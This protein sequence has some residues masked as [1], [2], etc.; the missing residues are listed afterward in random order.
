MEAIA[1]ATTM[2]NIPLS[3]VVTGENPRRH[4]DEQELKELTDSIRVNGVLQ[5]ILV[6]PVDGKFMIVA[7]ERRFRASLAAFGPEGEIPASIRELSD[8]DAQDAQSDF[9]GQAFRF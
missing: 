2:R 8:E 3:L 5:P 4:F 7:G 1:N 6:R 9:S